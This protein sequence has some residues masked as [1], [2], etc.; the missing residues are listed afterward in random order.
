M[1]ERDD[2]P[3]VGRMQPEE[4]DAAIM[5]GRQV[6]DEGRFVKQPKLPADRW[7]AEPD[8]SRDRRRTPRM[9]GEQL[10]DPEPGGIGEERDG[11]TV[12]LGH[13]RSLRAAA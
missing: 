13:Q 12:S 3:L 7:A 11:G 8:L 10:D 4:S 1:E 2:A 6:A 9:I 5:R